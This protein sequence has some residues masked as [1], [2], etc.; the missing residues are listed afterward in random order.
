MT[1]DR[2]LKAF[3]A[4]D[5]TL[6]TIPSRHGKLLVVL[7]RLAQE[8]EPGQRYEEAEVNLLLKRIHPD[9]AALRRYLVENGF[10]ARES[11]VYWRMGGTV[12]V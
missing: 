4:E 10:L 8:F 5:G 3:F 9:Y 6:H 7:D 11:G 1:D 2:V 12:D